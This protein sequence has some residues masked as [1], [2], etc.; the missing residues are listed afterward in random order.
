MQATANGAT[1][2]GAGAMNAAV[3][4]DGGV[5]YGLYATNSNGSVPTILASNTA[6]N[7]S[8]V[9]LNVQGHMQVKGNSVGQATIAAGHTSVTVTTSAATTASNVLLTLLSMY[10][11]TL[12][13][14]LAAGSFTIN[15]SAAPTS[16]IKIAYLI[17][18]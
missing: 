14:T 10:K 7:G 13:V 16:S 18:N 9:A 11:G 17:I 1:F 2:N 12:W 5:T 8:G 3:L 4:A 15:C 6:A